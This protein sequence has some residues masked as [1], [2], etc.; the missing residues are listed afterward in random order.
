M[1]T[2]KWNPPIVRTN[3]VEVDGKVYPRC[4]RALGIA[5]CCGWVADGAKDCGGHN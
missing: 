3:T 2:T 5:R 4:V 1:A